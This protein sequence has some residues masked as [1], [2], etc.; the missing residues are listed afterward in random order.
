MSRGFGRAGVAAVS[1]GG[2]GG[3]LAYVARLLRAVCAAWEG[4]DP[5]T[6]ALDPAH[7]GAVSGAERARFATRVVAAQLARRIDWLAFNHLGIA[8]VQRLVPRW[9]R[10]PYLVFVHDVEAWDPGLP[11]D[12]LATLRDAALRVANSRYTAG[13]V[14]AAHPTIGPVLA[15]P[16][17]LL[18]HDPVAD[19]ATAG[20]DGLPGDVVGGTSLSDGLSEIGPASVLILGRMHDEERYKGH[21]EL[22]ECWPAVVSRV[23]LAKLVIAGLGNDVPRLQAKAR[24]L[25]VGQCVLFCGFLPSPQL[26][27]LMNRVSVFAMP[28]AR[29]GFGLVYLEAMR[30]GRPCIGSTS[31][32]A[33][34]IIVHG[35]TGYLVDRAD[36]SA[37]SDA[38]IALLVDD[39]RRVA[40]GAAGRRRFED[41]F[42]A[43]RFAIR[44]RDILNDNPMIGHS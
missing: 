4:A 31:D 3:G 37:L 32:A 15:C 33:G 7:Y 25:G 23:P 44:L 17:G 13:R 22:L 27:A 41:C 18:D 8:R 42:T 11:A 38:I 30:A 2:R 34:D 20:P 9:V 43:E 26:A 29:E 21:D 14:T 12:R 10:R 40:M 28:S 6:A 24:A 19:G 39:R 36:R 1:F 16:L 5:W 35:E